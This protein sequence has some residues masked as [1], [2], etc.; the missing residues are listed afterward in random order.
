MNENDLI[1]NKDT[2]C[3]TLIDYLLYALRAR[4]NDDNT[5]KIIEST[6]AQMALSAMMYIVSDGLTVYQNHLL[7][8]LYVCT[9][10]VVSDL[11]L[12]KESYD[13]IVEVFGKPSP[14]WE[15]G[16]RSPENNSRSWEHFE[17]T[18]NEIQERRTTDGQD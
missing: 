10:D 15:R 2:V 7:I 12:L 5:Q 8:K 3:N 4:D 6:S 1:I 13:N 9:N 11:K 17:K 18:F 14:L 16:N